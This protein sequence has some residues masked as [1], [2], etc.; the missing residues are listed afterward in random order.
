MTL[1]EQEHAQ[2]SGPDPRRHR[3][4]QRK[5]LSRGPPARAPDDAHRPDPGPVTGREGRDVPARAARGRAQPAE[6]RDRPLPRERGNA[7]PGP[8]EPPC[9]AQPPLARPRH[10]DPRQAARSA[11]VRRGQPRVGHG[12]RLAG[13][14]RGYLGNGFVCHAFS[15]RPRSPGGDSPSESVD[16][17]AAHDSVRVALAPAVYA[18]LFRSG[19]RFYG[20]SHTAGGPRPGNPMHPVRVRS[21]R[22]GPSSAGGAL[23]HRVV[24]R[25]AAAPGQSPSARSPR[26]R[27]MTTHQRRSP[28][29]R[30]TTAPHR[31]APAHR[32]ARPR[33]ATPARQ[34]DA[35][36][37]VRRSQRPRYSRCHWVSGWPG[38][39]A[40]APPPKHRHTEPPVSRVTGTQRHPHHESPVSSTT[41][42]RAPA[43]PGSAP[44]A[45][46]LADPS[47]SPHAPRPAPHVPQPL[48]HHRCPSNSTPQQDSPSSTAP[49]P[50]VPQ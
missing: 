21:H 2:P 40:A 29:P 27:R 44:A 26:T 12:H 24:V 31:T 11:R 8:H 17:S 6:G 38:T 28:G 13:T 47:R 43:H 25:R 32:I 50:L 20:G 49:A 22:A 4:R 1:P 35:S 9:P 39:S 41:R 34:H 5:R 23:L 15:L 48:A 18:P 30:R 46:N 10:R 19:R 7:P 45:R 36:S 16:N 33:P 3:L 37:S 14:G 42:V